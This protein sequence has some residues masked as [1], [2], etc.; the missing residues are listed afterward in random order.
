MATN[1]SNR[2]SDLLNTA[3]LKRLVTFDSCGM[4]RPVVHTKEKTPTPAIDKYDPTK[5]DPTR[6][7]VHFALS[8]PN[9]APTIPPASTKDTARLR[10]SGGA[11]S[12]AAKR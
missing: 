11:T 8:G 6:S 7:L 1:T 12:T 2:L 9:T 10:Y 4:T 5:V 3:Q